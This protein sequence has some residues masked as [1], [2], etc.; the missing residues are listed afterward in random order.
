MMKTNNQEAPGHQEEINGQ[1]DS[2]K[3]RFSSDLILGFH[4]TSSFSK[5]KKYQ[6]L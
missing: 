3:Y 1:A 4:V 6:S 5:T 2:Q